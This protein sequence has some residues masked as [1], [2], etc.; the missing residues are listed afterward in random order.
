MAFYGNQSVNDPH[1]SPLRMKRKIHSPLLGYL[2]QTQMLNELE[3]SWIWTRTCIIIQGDASGQR[4]PTN[5]SFLT[6]EVFNFKFHCRFIYYLEMKY[7]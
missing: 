2:C 5:L 6:T 1:G 4:D 7:L 3:M